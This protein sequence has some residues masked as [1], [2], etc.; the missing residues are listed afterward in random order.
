MS[1]A[2]GRRGRSWWPGGAEH[3][4]EYSEGTRGAAADLGITLE[5]V[6]HRVVTSTGLLKP[7]EKA[8]P[9]CPPA[10]EAR[11]GKRPIAPRNR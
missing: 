10:V 8:S 5:V 1:F 2:Q 7:V 11:N 9:V 6:G 3:G 4:S